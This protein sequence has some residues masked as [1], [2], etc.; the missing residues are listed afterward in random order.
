MKPL[1]YQ[2]AFDRIR[3]EFGEM[4]GMHLTPEQ[5]ARLSRVETAIC[6]TVLD[7]LARAG[8]LCIS[9]NGTYCLW[10]DTSTRTGRKRAES[11]KVPR[12]WGN[13]MRADSE[14][15]NCDALPAESLKQ[16]TP[17]GHDATSLK[18][19]KTHRCCPH[20]GTRLTWI[21]TRRWQGVAYDYYRDCPSGCGLS[22]FNRDTQAFED[23]ITR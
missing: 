18:V 6:K 19:D 1:P 11:A 17:D 3:A 21:E 7:D 5:V 15:S 4:P 8:F 13:A 9:A 14:Q 23:L 20:C 22:C 12:P 10:S 2:Q 16:S